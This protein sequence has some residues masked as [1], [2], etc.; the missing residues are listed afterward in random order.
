MQNVIKRMVVSIA[1]RALGRNR[2]RKALTKKKPFITEVV[3]I[4]NGLPSFRRLAGLRGLVV[5]LGLKQGLNSRGGQQWR[6]FR[7]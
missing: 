6:I 4:G 1:L 5:T 7:Q 3:G 2:Y